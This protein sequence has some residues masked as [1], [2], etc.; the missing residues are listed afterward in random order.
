MAEADE[1]D[2]LH[3][4]SLSPQERIAALEMIRAMNYGYATDDQPLP[5]LQRVYRVAEL[6]GS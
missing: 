4:L 6:R 3:W 2:R 1:R 5:R